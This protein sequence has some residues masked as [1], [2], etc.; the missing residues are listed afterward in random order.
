MSQT[1]G[2]LAIMILEARLTRDTEMFGKMDPYVLGETRMQR[3]RTETQEDAGK[4]PTWANE[5]FNVD[6]KYIGDDMHLMVM[7]ENVTDSDTVGECT[8]KLS[9]LCVDGGLDEWFAIQYKGEE[10]G[11]LRLKSKW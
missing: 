5:V 2:K 11:H 7:D 8:I 10:A 6:V 3:F 4:T 1:A 9:S